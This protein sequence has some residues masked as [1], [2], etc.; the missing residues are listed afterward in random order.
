METDWSAWHMV[1]YGLTLA[2]YEALLAARFK[3][4]RNRM[5]ITYDRGTAEIMVPG[6]DPAEEAPPQHDGLR[7]TGLRHEVTRKRI[8]HLIEGWLCETGGH[9][10][11]AGH[12]TVSRPDRDLGFDAD[13]VYFVQS[14]KR[15]V[16]R[17]E[18]D[19]TIDPVP[20]L[21]VEAAPHARVVDRDAVLAG[22]DIPEVWRYDA[23]WLSAHLR[24]AAGR[25]QESGTSRAI[26]GFPFADV[27]QFVTDEPEDFGAFNREYRAWVR[28]RNPG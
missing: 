4:R 23:G 11:A 24:G 20:D 25:Y 5:R 18:P 19:F 12:T 9:F 6:V 27:Q 7:V 17:L 3:A 15:M 16:P 13:E 26:P 21:V 28:F 8:A 14:W 10:A 22:L 2:D 1:L